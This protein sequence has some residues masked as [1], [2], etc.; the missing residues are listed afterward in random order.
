MYPYFNNQGDMIAF[1]GE[2]E[3]RINGAKRIAI[4]RMQTVE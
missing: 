1:L 4:L 3:K 2:Y